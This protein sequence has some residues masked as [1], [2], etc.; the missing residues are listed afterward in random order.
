MT[1]KLLARLEHTYNVSIPRMNA[2][3]SV[4]GAAPRER[5]SPDSSSGQR[6]PD[7]LHLSLEN[8]RLG[9]VQFTCVQ[10]GSPL[11]ISHEFAF[12]EL[13]DLDTGVQN[14]LVAVDA[15]A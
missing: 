10:A 2:L 15:K 5:R 3:L 13:F 8:S 1:R 4:I 7:E 11:Q 14:R 6:R 12:Y 9:R